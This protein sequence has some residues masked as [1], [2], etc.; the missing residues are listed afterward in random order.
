MLVS[1]GLVTAFK[2]LYT[3][4]TDTVDRPSIKP[5]AKENDSNRVRLFTEIMVKVITIYRVS[6]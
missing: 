3:E 2:V 1:I 6:A 4:S 5:P